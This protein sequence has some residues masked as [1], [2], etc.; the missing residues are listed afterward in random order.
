MNVTG[1][2]KIIERGSGWA[3][4]VEI[5]GK[6]GYIGKAFDGVT[7]YPS[8]AEA[9]RDAERRGYLIVNKQPKIFDVDERGGVPVIETDDPAGILALG[10]VPLIGVITPQPDRVYGHTFTMPDV[11][12]ALARRNGS[13]AKGQCP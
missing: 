10:D 7:I 13:G 9:Q 8:F 3:I 2:A 12:A 6:V 4:E 5:A 11:S 1:K